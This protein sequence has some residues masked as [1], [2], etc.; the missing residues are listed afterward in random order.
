MSERESIE[1][2]RV[3]V[4]SI[5]TGGSIIHRQTETD[6]SRLREKNGIEEQKKKR[7]QQKSESILGEPEKERKK[8]RLKGGRE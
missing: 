7:R 4:L 6:S 8:E 1:Q 2:G 5:C 3:V